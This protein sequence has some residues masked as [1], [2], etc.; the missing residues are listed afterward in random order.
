VVLEQ[1]IELLQTV[2]AVGRAARLAVLTGVQMLAHL[3][4]FAVN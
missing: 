2:L 3:A 1:K 4:D